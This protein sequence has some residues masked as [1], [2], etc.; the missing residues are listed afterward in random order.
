MKE[1][2]DFDIEDRMAD[3]FVGWVERLLSGGYRGFGFSIADFGFHGNKRSF[4][5]SEFRLAV[6]L[7]S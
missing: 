5:E 4:E 2:R 7:K 1:W 3:R 6:N